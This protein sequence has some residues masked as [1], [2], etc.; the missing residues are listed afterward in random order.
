MTAAG[1]LRQAKCSAPQTV[2]VRAG[3]LARY[4]D[5]SCHGS[6]ADNALSRLWGT[7]WDAVS[8]YPRKLIYL[9]LYKALISLTLPE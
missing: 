8:M 1:P 6:D 3:D 7:P 2:K 9:Q 5:R 4:D